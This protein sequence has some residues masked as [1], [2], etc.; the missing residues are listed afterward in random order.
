MRE[1]GRGLVALYEAF[2]R[3]AHFAYI[4]K[5]IG[6]FRNPYLC[7]DVTRVGREPLR[8]LSAGDRLVEH[9][10]GP[11]LRYRHARPAAGRRRRAALRQPRGRAERGNARRLV[12]K[13]GHQGRPGPHRLPSRHRPAAAARRTGLRRSGTYHRQN[14][15]STMKRPS[16]LLLLL[17]V[18]CAAVLPACA[19]ADYRTPC[20][21]GRSK[22]TASLFHL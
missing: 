13:E 1:S 19:Q 5:I 22:R 6:R 16:P 12:E 17:A 18:C 8:K 3:D 4:D 7:D 14:P 20:G 11:P 9:P 2:D 21:S 10:H 15:R